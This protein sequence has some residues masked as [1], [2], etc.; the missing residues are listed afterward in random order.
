MRIFMSYSSLN[1]PRVRELVEALD[2]FAYDV[3]FDQDLTGGQKWWDHIL[4]QIRDCDLFMFAL[5]PAWLESRPCQLEFQYA[6][7]LGK[8][9][10]PV[11][12]A[13]VEGYPRADVGAVQYVDY[14]KDTPDH[15]KSVVRAINQQ[16]AP[17]ALPDPLPA[18]PALPVSVIARLGAQLAAPSLSGKEQNEILLRLRILLD[19]PRDGVQALKLL[20]ELRTHPDVRVA[21]V[22]AI[23]ELLESRQAK[24]RERREF[25]IIDVSAPPERIVA[26]SHR[27]ITSRNVTEIVQTAELIIN[28]ITKDHVPEEYFEG[29]PCSN[30]NPQYVSQFVFSPDGA[31]L[32]VV[33]HVV[34]SFSKDR[35]WLPWQRIHPSKTECWIC[36]LDV[37]QLPE[38]ELL[39]SADTHHPPIEF[40]QVPRLHHLKFSSDGK[41][42]LAIYDTWN[43]RTSYL[44]VLNTETWQE[45]R[46]K[47]LPFYFLRSYSALDIAPGQPV[48]AI[49]GYTKAY[50]G[51]TTENFDQPGLWLYDWQR[52]HVIVHIS[53]DHDAFTSVAFAPQGHFLVTTQRSSGVKFWHTPV[54]TEA[55]TW[56]ENWPKSKR[57][58]CVFQR[59]TD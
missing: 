42:L 34:F 25:Q 15:F 47:V 4:A 51:P 9:V 48:V 20:D 21:T 38:Y 8:N 50:T 43:N 59:W 5:S 16:P 41:Q 49:A 30:G 31:A 46:R 35:Q 24:E 55:E 14:L 2:D 3:W 13:D 1:R 29:D 27:A 54:M 52:D 33:S 19:D 45:E 44:S 32:A 39:Y 37:W 22:D 23:D 53:P 26:L 10:L 28:P 6:Q 17:A 56:P 12:I 58:S 40:N 18:P 7:A 11:Q 36:R 57:R